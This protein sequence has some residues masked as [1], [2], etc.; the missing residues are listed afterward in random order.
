MKNLEM[1]ARINELWNNGYSEE[2]IYFGDKSIKSFCQGGI[3]AIL[4]I[5]AVESVIKKF[6]LLR[7]NTKHFKKSR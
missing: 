4:T 2:L 3:I 1:E 5:Y 6:V 7:R